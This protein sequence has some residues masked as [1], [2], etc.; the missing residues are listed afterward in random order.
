MGQEYIPLAPDPKWVGDH[1]QQSLQ[2]V[3][4]NDRNCW[5]PFVT[6]WLTVFPDRDR[7]QWC[8]CGGTK[9][10]FQASQRA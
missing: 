8:Y 5:E 10:T 6:D 9:H 7:T 2:I 3:K 1:V 4:C